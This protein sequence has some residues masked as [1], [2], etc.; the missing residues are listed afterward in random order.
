MEDENGFKTCTAVCIL[1]LVLGHPLAQAQAEDL[2]VF[3]FGHSLLDH[4]PPSI[5]TP[6][7]ETTIF[8]WMSLL[9]EADDKNFSAGGKYGFLPQ[10]AILPPISQ[11]AYDRVDPVW[12][13]DEESFADSK[14][15]TVLITAG[16][17]MQWQGPDQEYPSDPGVSAISAT[18]TIVDWVLEQ[19]AT[20]RLYIYENW[21]DMFP[22]LANGFPPSRSELDAYADYTRGDFH[23]WWIQYQDALLESRPQAEVRM[24]PVGPILH[25]IFD[26][27]VPRDVD[28]QEFY[29]DD[30]PHGRATLYFMAAMISYSAICA[31]PLPDNYNPPMIV[32][33]SI[34]NNYEAIAQLIWEELVEFNDENGQSRV[35]FRTTQ[36]EDVSSKKELTFFPNPTNG[37]ISI[38]NERSNAKIKV[39]DLLGHLRLYREVAHGRTE[40]QLQLSSGVYLLEIS[41]DR[42][43]FVEC[44]KLIVR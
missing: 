23:A 25:E 10:H 37:K 40:L 4:R 35:F 2:G 8:H 36:S 13:S 27:F 14:I 28:L 15:N 18:E 24:I 12:E 11:W 43:G 1:L 34:R 19:D 42:T 20:N 41:D 5:P 17:F 26:A 7:D 31:S 6:S 16:N 30:A 39:Y 9:A 32:H 33:E 29:E 21:P 22:F 44:E 38:E 3:A